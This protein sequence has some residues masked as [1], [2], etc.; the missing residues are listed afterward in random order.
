VQPAEAI[1]RPG[2][3]RDNYTARGKKWPML[4]YRL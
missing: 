2:D 3:W 1:S 4:E